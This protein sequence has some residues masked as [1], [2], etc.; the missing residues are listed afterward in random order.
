MKLYLSSYRLGNHPEALQVLVPP[1][2]NVA[3]VFNARDAFG[4]DRLR[5]FDRERGELEELGYTCRELDLRAHFERPSTLRKALDEV[6]LVWAV[7]GNAFVLARAMTLAGF[8]EASRD[9]VVDGSLV[10]AGY[11]AGACVAGPDLEGIALMDEPDAT[12][13]GYPAGI[14]ATTLGWIQ[15]RIVPHWR[16]NH[17]ESERAA[18][19]VRYLSEKGLEYRALSDGQALIIDGDSMQVL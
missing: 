9:R 17:P 1:A 8:E 4:P 6:G 14:P 12:P 10:Y 18:T 3:L 13:E 2:T 19:S 7:G 5:A 16:S 15:T 11:S